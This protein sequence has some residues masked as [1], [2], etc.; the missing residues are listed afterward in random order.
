MHVHA[1]VHNNACGFVHVPSFI[2]KPYHHLVFDH[3]KQGERPRSIYHVSGIK[4]L[5]RGGGAPIKRM[6]FLRHIVC[7]EQQTALQTFGRY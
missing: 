5:P 7:P 4:C 1:V 6:H 3:Q 2:P